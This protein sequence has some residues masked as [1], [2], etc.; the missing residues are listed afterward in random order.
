MASFWTRKLKKNRFSIGIQF[1]WIDLTPTF[2]ISTTEPFANVYFLAN[3]HNVLNAFAQMAK[4]SLFSAKKPLSHSHE[5]NGSY[6]RSISKPFESLRLTALTLRSK[7][8]K[9][10]AYH[11]N[12]TIFLVFF[13]FFFHSQIVNYDKKNEC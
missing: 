7:L 8:F 13:S 12:D 4:L 3:I 6:K 11:F 1:E 9:S 10:T 5:M 2:E